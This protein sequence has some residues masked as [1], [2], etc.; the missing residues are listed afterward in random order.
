MRLAFY[1]KLKV[2][3]IKYMGLWAKRNTFPMRTMWGI[4]VNKL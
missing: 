1:V 2:D 4:N 3:S